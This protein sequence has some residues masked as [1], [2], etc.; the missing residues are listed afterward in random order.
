M[1]RNDMQTDDMEKKLQDGRKALGDEA[2]SVAFTC[3]LPCA[4]AGDAEAQVHIGF[5]YSMGLGVNRDLLKAIDWLRRAIAQGR[6]DAAHNLA[7]L[8]LTC[9]P[10]LPREPEEARK[11]YLKARELGFVVAPED[12][13]EQM[14]NEDDS[15]GTD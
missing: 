2:Y 10:E 14:R 13:Y 15:K 5:L 3:L 12:W 11:L 1:E 6:G 4:E 7:T 8:Y 9:E